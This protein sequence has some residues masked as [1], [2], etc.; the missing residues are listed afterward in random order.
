MDPPDWPTIRRQE[1]PT[2][3]H[4]TLQNVAAG[5]LP[6]RRDG[7]VFSNREQRL[8]DRP[9]GYY[10][11]YTVAMPGAPDR[12]PRRLVLGQR[13]EMYYSEDHYATF[14]EVVPS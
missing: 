1:L 3:A 11:E 12:G 8:P 13:S 4:D 10:R 7:I 2:E 5:T 6:H 9:H 14:V